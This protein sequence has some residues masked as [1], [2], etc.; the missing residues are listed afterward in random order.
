MTSNKFIKRIQQFLSDNIQELTKAVNSTFNAPPIKN[1]FFQIPYDN[2][3][4]LYPCTYVH[5]QINDYDNDTDTNLTSTIPLID[6]D[7]DDNDDG[8]PPLIE[9]IDSGAHAC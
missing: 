6:I 7:D 4:G 9:T 2:S 3:T 5:P 1:S 8:P